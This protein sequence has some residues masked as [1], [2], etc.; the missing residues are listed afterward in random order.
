MS[1]KSKKKCRCVSM[2]ILLW[3]IMMVLV[4]VTV[5]FMWVFQIHF[6]ERNYIES[7][8]SEVQAQVEAVLDDLKTEDL[9]Y[10]EQLLSSLSHAAD[11]KLLIVNGSGQLIDLYTLGHPIDLKENRTDILV[12]ERIADGENYAAILAGETYCHETVEGNRIVS[13]E[14]GVPVRYYGEDAYLILYHS[15]SELYTVLDM[16]RQQLVMLTILLTLISAVLAGVLSKLF[17]SPILTIKKTVDALAAGDLTAKPGLKRRD[18]IG[19]LSYSVEKLGQALQRVDVLRKEVIANVSH[20]LRSPLALIGG[21]AEMVRDITWKDDTQREENLNLIISEAN[22]MSVMVSDILD[23]SQ[24]QSGCLQLNRG[25]Y[26]LC[27]IVEHEVRRCEQIAQE[28]HLALSF[29]G[30]GEELNVQVDALKISQVVRNLLNNAINH[31]KDGETIT[32]SVGKDRQGYLVRVVNPG[33]PIP[34]EDRAIIWE[35]YQRSQ[36]QAGRRQGTGI[37]LSIV[38]TILDA[39]GMTY[40]VDCRDGL[41]CFW[42]RYPVSPLSSN[43]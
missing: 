11:G 21:Y 4:L 5:A 15:F 20:E 34:E 22:R 2:A 38:K 10:N 23:Y 41:T 25:S 9:A 24:L 14:Q 31:T 32:V 19:Q 17:T 16:N 13:Y 28:N 40:G 3:G 35:R 8:I 39:H 42:F 26:D 37:G 29:E 27:E 6:M 18:E 43:Q 12:W 30:P 1:T 36:H 7:N 33:E